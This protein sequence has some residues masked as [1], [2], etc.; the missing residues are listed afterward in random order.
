MGYG[1]INVGEGNSILPGGQGFLDFLYGNETVGW[2]EPQ[3]N[4][5][6][7]LK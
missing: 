7:P 5:N 6:T 4:A 2:C 1:G 3:A